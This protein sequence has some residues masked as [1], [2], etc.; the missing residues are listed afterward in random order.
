MNLSTTYFNTTSN[1]PINLNFTAL[2]PI[3]LTAI[4]NNNTPTLHRN[5]QCIPSVLDDLQ[6][7]TTDEISTLTSTEITMSG[8]IAFSSIMATYALYV[9]SS[10][11][12]GTFTPYNILLFYL[13]IS[14]TCSSLTNIFIQI[15][16]VRTNY[17]SCSIS[18]HLLQ[19]LFFFFCQWSYFL[20]IT[21]GIN[22][23][24]KIRLLLD[25]D[26]VV[27]L[28]TCKFA[29]IVVIILSIVSTIAGEIGFQFLGK[30][31]RFTVT[32]PFNCPLIILVLILYIM[33]L[34]D[35]K[36]IG[37]TLSSLPRGIKVIVRVST[38]HILTLILLIVPLCTVFVVRRIKLLSQHDVTLMLFWCLFLFKSCSLINVFNV[39]ILNKRCRHVFQS[40]NRQ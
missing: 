31:A 29:S 40:E 2:S 14:D 36:D 18:S 6:L 5:H 24:L 22:R 19:T 9:S 10:T 7:L 15:C 20:L 8:I 1:Q 21:S 11:N 25:Y 13:S 28:K 16:L 38:I 32:F 33:S 23:F 34:K 30:Y 35:L 12:G 4:P 26:R 17:D 27:S 3:N 39:F 37:A